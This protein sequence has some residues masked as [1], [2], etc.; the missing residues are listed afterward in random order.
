MLQNFVYLN[1]C[2]L[3][4]KF[5]ALNFFLTKWQLLELEIFSLSASSYGSKFNSRAVEIPCPTCPTWSHFLQDKL[6]ISIYLSKYKCIK[7]TKFCIS[8]FD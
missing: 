7:M 8:Y 5:D 6:K 1:L 3:I 4:K 2:H